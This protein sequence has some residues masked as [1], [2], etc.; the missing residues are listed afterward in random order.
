MK[1]TMDSMK[2]ILAVYDTDE[3]YGKR[4]SEYFNRKESI[5]FSMVCFTK[6]DTLVMYAEE[7][8]I[9][10]LLLPESSMSQK[11]ARLPVKRIV[12]L[13]E[14]HR[15]SV[16]ADKH[17]VYKFQSSDHVIR[18][19]MSCY[20]TMDMQV[21]ETIAALH[22]VQ[23][24]GVYSPL[25]RCL[26]TSFA[27]TLGQVLSKT[28]Q[29]LYLNFEEFSGLEALLGKVF[30]ADLSD[31]VFYYTQGQ[32]RQQ[33]EGLTESWHNLDYLPPVRYPED[34]FEMTPDTVAGLVEEIARVCHYDVIILDFGASIRMAEKLFPMC[35]KIYMPVR[36]DPVSEGKLES[37]E[38][39]MKMKNRTE[40]LARIERLKLPFY[41]GFGSGEMYLEQMLWGELGDYV[42]TLVKG[43]W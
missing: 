20:E 1:G 36:E 39:W 27:L 30:T 38:S 10:M 41:R 31:A 12:Y 4:L 35:Q 43:E 8:P 7:H 32:L 6:E 13:A 22:P 33:M 2:K 14:E 16:E 28:K 15:A 25:S 9:D 17:F 34:L 23:I 3:E 11:I 5:P 21:M 40:I 26:K 29:I 24:A 19:L 42:R 18:E 37:F